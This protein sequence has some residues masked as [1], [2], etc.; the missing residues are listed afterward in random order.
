MCKSFSAACLVALTMCMLVG[1]NAAGK[2][3]AAKSSLPADAVQLERKPGEEHIQ[4]MAVCTTK[5]SHE[6]Y[7]Y[8]LTKWLDSKDKAMVYGKEHARKKIGHVVVYN[9]RMKR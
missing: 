9:E 3:K 7:E 1:C 2:D 6:G 5:Q 8:I 4:Y